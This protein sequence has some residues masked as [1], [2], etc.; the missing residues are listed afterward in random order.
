MAKPSGFGD[1]LSASQTETAPETKE[2][3][4]CSCGGTSRGSDVTVRWALNLGRKTWG[5]GEENI[6][7][8]VRTAVLFVCD[9]C[10]RPKG[11]LARITSRGADAGQ[12]RRRERLAIERHSSDSGRSEQK[13]L[14]DAEFYAA[15]ALGNI[16]ET[17]IGKIPGIDQIPDSLL[18]DANRIAHALEDFTQAT[19]SLDPA[20]FAT[21]GLF[22][23]TNGEILMAA[24]GLPLMQYA[25]LRMER[26]P[27]I[28]GL[29][30][31]VDMSWKDIPGWERP[32]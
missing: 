26:A 12:Q 6:Y 28:I 10:A 32:G 1:I 25:Y 2:G 8:D 19:G 9:I 29:K 27:G 7:Y 3:R 11:F 30:T 5:G 18:S 31:F 4:C 13:Y 20:Q 16:V 23:K 24:G 17:P 21:W 22:F 15:K 14:T